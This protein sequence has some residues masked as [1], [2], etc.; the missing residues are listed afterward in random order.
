MQWITAY[1]QHG[2]LSTRDVNVLE[3]VLPTITHV[4]SVFTMTP[5]QLAGMTD[6]AAADGGDSLIVAFT[7]ATL[8]PIYRNAVFNKTIRAAL[9]LMKVL[10]FTGDITANFGI[11]ALWQIEDDD[12][13]AGGGFVKTEFLNGTNHFVSSA[14]IP[15]SAGGH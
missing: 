12:A 15:L 10:E 2:D 8:L 5:D 3:Y 6:I 9:P 7:Q 14:L 1:F 11:V 13:A 4:P